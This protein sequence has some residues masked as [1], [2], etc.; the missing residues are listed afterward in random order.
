M[1][2]VQEIALVLIF[3]NIKG[4]QYGFYQ[5]GHELL[6]KEYL[7]CPHILFSI[8]DVH[9]KLIYALLFVDGIV[10]FHVFW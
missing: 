8:L 7:N 2:Q 10:F 5:L 1:S 6:A 9:N 4:W 3:G